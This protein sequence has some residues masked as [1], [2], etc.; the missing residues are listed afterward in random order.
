MTPNYPAPGKAAIAPCLQ[1]D[2]I[3]AACLSRV[4]RHE[5]N[6]QPSTAKSAERSALHPLSGD[7]VLPE[8]LR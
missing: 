6:C 2:I 5:C 7:G 4:V 3:V 8:L 1:S